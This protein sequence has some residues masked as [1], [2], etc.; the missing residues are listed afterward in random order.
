MCVR[1]RGGFE[2]KKGSLL[3]IPNT[4]FNS[5]GLA[6]G[7]SLSLTASILMQMS[8]P[9]MYI[10]LRKPPPPL[11]PPPSHPTTPRALSAY[12]C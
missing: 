4:A 9:L 12:S 1:E 5:K 11:P 7:L 10:T 8:G 2:K 6:S 3:D